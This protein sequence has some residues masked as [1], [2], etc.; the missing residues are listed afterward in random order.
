MLLEAGEARS[1]CRER[2]DAIDL[3]KSNDSKAGKIGSGNEAAIGPVAP[4]A[5]VA[6]EGPPSLEFSD[7]DLQRIDDSVSDF[8]AEEGKQK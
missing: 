7:S 1:A 3:T 8:H 2:P 6:Q 4:N 5:G